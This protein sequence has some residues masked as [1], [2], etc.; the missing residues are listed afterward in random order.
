ME[1][2]K[3]TDEV[4]KG[5]PISTTKPKKIGTLVIGKKR[6]DQGSKYWHQGWHW[7][8]FGNWRHICPF[9]VITLVQYLAFH[10]HP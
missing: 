5:D 7:H 8:L 3:I 6:K 2:G 1:Q 10:E 4:W 9:F